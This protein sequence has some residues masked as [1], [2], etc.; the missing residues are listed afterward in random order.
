MAVRKLNK[1]TYY[2]EY[3]ILRVSNL[4]EFFELYQYNNQ[5]YSPPFALLSKLEQAV[6]LEDDPPTE[7]N[8]Q[9]EDCGRATFLLRG[10]EIINEM[11]IATYYFIG[12]NK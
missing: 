7:V 9:F 11:R 2:K 4:N 6:M 12:F 5:Y 3:N 8:C 10:I 1:E